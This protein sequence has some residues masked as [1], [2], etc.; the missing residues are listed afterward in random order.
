AAPAALPRPEDTQEDV[1]VVTGRTANG[2]PQRRRKSRATAPAQPA[3]QA[4]TAP[5]TADHRSSASE[6]APEVQ[7][8]MWLAAFQSGLS[9]DPGGAAGPKSD[10]SSEK[11]ELP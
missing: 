1:P 7:P 5:D 11:S 4:S 3:P 6:A 9:G 10:E 2:L 8:G